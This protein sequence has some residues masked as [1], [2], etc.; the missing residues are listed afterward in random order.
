MCSVTKEDLEVAEKVI[1]ASRHVRRTPLLSGFP[2]CSGVDVYLKMESM[3][4]LFAPLSL[5]LTSRKIRIL[6]H[7]TPMHTARNPI[8]CGEYGL[9]QNKRH[10]EHVRQSR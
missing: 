4:V 6:T 9:I 10:G 8:I 2:I 5:N 7:Y 1:S 3:Q